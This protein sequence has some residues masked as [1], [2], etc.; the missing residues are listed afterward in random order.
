MSY[1]SVRNKTSPSSSDTRTHQLSLKQRVSEALPFSGWEMVHGTQARRSQRVF[2]PSL[3]FPQG[4]IVLFYANTLA[5]AGKVPPS[6]PDALC[7]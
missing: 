3:H 4:K 7:S 2:S 5:L 6:L 1:F